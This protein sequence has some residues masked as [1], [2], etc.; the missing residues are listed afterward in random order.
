MNIL[1][2]I[3]RLKISEYFGIVNRMGTKKGFTIIEALVS[4]IFLAIV[5][6][7]IVNVS[8][9]SGVIG[10]YSKHK[11]QAIYVVQRALEDLHKKS[12]SQITSGTSTVSVDTRGTPDTTSDD[13]LGTQTIT[14]TS[15]SSY[16]KKAVVEVSWTESIFGKNKVV[17][18]SCGTFISNDPQIN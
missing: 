4:I 1:Y 11:V 9:I 13:L 12:F 2:H 8:V 5:W 10:S 15:P 7:A 16:Y 6:L 14:I 18:E 3:F 17:R